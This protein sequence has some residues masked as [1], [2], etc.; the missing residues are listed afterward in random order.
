MAPPLT[1]EFV[2]RFAIFFGSHFSVRLRPMRH[3]RRCCA[4][5]FRINVW[6]NPLLRSEYKY[7]YLLPHD[8]SRRLIAGLIVSRWWRWSYTLNAFQEASCLGHCLR[9]LRNSRSVFLAAWRACEVSGYR[10]DRVDSIKL[11]SS[12]RQN[13][14][15]MVHGCE[16]SK[17][18]PRYPVVQCKIEI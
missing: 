1:A 9:Y 18:P 16:R 3:H 15:L 2:F 12:Y 4:V 8:A 5:H 10:T 11:F 7:Y 17:Q 6:M 14:G 13:M